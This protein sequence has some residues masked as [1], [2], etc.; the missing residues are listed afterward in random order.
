MINIE[1]ESAIIYCDGCQSEIARPH[2]H[3]CAKCYA[4][5]MAPK[6]LPDPLPWIS[7]N[8]RLPE[9]DD[10]VLAFVEYDQFSITAYYLKDRWFV[11]AQV[12]DYTE[13]KGNCTID[14]VLHNF[15]VTHWMPL[16]PIPSY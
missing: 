9:T 4:N 11:G 12:R 15:K 16:P 13:S 14:S 3:Y 1:G 5:Y 7:V 2:E 10:D 8:D 6:N